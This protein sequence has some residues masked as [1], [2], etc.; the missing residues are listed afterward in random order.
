MAEQPKARITPL[1]R[2]Q[3]TD[4]A[5]DVFAFWEGPEAREQ[6]SRTNV[7]MVLANHP[8]LGQA[9]NQYSKHLLIDNTVPNREREL[10]ILRV[11]FR[12]KSLYEWHYHVGYGLNFGLTLDEIAAIRLPPGEGD[13]SDHDRAILEAVDQLFADGNI[14]DHTWETLAEAFDRRQMMDLV[15]MI[16]HYTMTS[17]ALTAFGV[18]LED[19]NDPIGFDLR[20]A[21]GKTPQAAI[22]P[23][24]D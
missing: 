15:M 21:S 3:W 24:E 10:V 13:W 4:A 19:W 17:W 1:P 18:Q 7:M 22:R 9:Y 2:E 14:D 5:R 8:Q 11:A 23:V 16:G 6:G 20:T 12:T